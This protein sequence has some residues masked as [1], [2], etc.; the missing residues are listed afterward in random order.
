MAVSEGKLRTCVVGCKRGLRV[1]SQVQ[2]LP[3]YEFVGACD[4]IEE[5]ARKA[6][7]G[8]G[9]LSVWTDMEE[10]GRAHV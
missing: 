4:L 2:V 1:G 10:I 6:A 3:E 9:A 8:L 5:R 7:E